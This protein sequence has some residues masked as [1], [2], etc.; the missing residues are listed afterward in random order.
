MRKEVIKTTF[1]VKAHTIMNFNFVESVVNT[2]DLNM[3]DAQCANL[4]SEFI[5]QV[6]NKY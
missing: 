3:I 5:F 4:I 6:D 1:T 2:I